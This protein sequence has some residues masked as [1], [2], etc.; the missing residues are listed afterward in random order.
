MF[1]KISTMKTNHE[2]KSFD[3]RTANFCG[4]LCKVNCG[5]TYNP[6]ESADYNIDVM[7]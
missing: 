2:A 7:G 1:K 4:G 5:A 3:E 6:S